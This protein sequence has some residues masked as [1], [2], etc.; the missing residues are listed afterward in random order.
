LDIPDELVVVLNE[1]NLTTTSSIEKCVHAAS[2][3]YKVLHSGAPDD[4]RRIRAC[5]EQRIFLANLKQN[6]CKKCVE[7]IKNKID[8]IVSKGHQSTVITTLSS[9][10]SISNELKPLKA[11]IPYLVHSQINDVKNVN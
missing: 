8:A 9:H 2:E 11:V 5:D 7:N 10:R 1:C 6:F 4:F 3:L